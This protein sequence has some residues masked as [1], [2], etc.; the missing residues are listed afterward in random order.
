M[1]CVKTPLLRGERLALGCALQRRE[2]GEDRPGPSVKKFALKSEKVINRRSLSAVA[3]A[4]PESGG[5]REILEDG[6]S[7]TPI[8]LGPLPTRLCFHLR[9]ERLLPPPPAQERAAPKP[10]CPCGRREAGEPLALSE[11]ALKSVSRCARDAERKLG[12]GTSSQRV[13]PLPSP[14][15]RKEMITS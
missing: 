7:R 8:S 9:S 12:L 2:A 6:E 5:G 11:T 13:E 10:P 4:A 3:A 15:N 1:G 14:S